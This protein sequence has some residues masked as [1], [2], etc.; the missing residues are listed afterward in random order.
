MKPFKVQYFLM[1]LIKT[2][3][4][5]AKTANDAEQDFFQKKGKYPLF[6]TVLDNQ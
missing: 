4:T 2:Y 6:R 1:A 5:T 3:R